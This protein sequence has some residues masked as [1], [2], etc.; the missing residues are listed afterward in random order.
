MELEAEWRADRAR[1]W[2]LARARADYTAA[3]LAAALGRSVS[4]VKKWRRRLGRA[5]WGDEAALHSRSRARRR[6]PPAVPPLVVERLL[7]IRDA[8]PAHLQRTPGPKAILYFL[9]HD[10]EL[11]AAGL[12]LPRSTATVWRLLRRHG[13]IAQRRPPPREPWEL[14][15]PMTSWQL[16]FKDVSSVRGDR[17]DPTAKRQHAV[18]SLDCVDCGT[19]LLVD[20]VVRDD[21]T[22]ETTLTTVADL[23]RAHGRPQQITLDRDPRFVGAPGAGDFPSPLVRF[24]TC[25]GV[26]VQINPPHRPDLNGY[27]E[28][29]HRTLEEECLR[30]HRPAT[31]EVAREVTAAFR[32]HYNTER[33][34]QARSCGNRPPL[35][36][37]PDLPA[38]PPVPPVVDPDGWLPLVD[39]RRFRRTVKANG[40]VVVEHHRYY[41]GRRWQGQRVLVAV[42]AGE[43]ELAVWRGPTLLKCLPLHGL[44][45]APLPFEW[46]VTQMEQE[47][48]IHTLRRPWMRSTA[49]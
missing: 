6:P 34:N 46:Y 9:R 38:L 17:S 45:G 33:P 44:C 32:E 48:R 22:E 35:A 39:G 37:F 12:P 23:L 15:E 25:L 21:F 3:D 2:A 11:Q 28:R 5:T 13:R 47:A 20:A 40:S 14:A 43:R 18:E 26:E 19:S 41:V 16:D 24:L 1:L 31:L 42:D 30:V 8:P 4:W 49:A 10:P 7:A 29:F 27:V 36:A